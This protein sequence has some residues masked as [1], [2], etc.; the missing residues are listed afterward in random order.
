MIGFVVCSVIWMVAFSIWVTMLL[1]YIRHYP[2]YY[3]AWQTVFLF[4]GGLALVGS[5]IA[6]MTNA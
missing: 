1:D 2:P 4:I 5:L 3:R 6:L